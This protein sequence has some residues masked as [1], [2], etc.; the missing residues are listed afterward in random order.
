LSGNASQQLGTN[1][2]PAIIAPLFPNFGGLRFLLVG[3]FEIRADTFVT[4]QPQLV[5]LRRI[6][7]GHP[8]TAAAGSLGQRLIRRP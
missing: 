4:E 6:E 8:T 7:H 2:Q 5:E 1:S 3:Q